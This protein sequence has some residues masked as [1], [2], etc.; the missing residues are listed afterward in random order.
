MVGSGIAIV[1][2]YRKRS[3]RADLQLSEFLDTL[4]PSLVLKEEIPAKTLPVESKTGRIN[5]MMN[6]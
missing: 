5:L 4:D 1:N 6:C 3:A 2:R